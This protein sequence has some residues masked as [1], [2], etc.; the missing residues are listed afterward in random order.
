M[1]PF[2]PFIQLTLHLYIY[3]EREVWNDAISGRWNTG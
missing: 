3:A 1:V 2:C